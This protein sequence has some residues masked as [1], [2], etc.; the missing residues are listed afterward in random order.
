MAGYRLTVRAG[1]K[2]SRERFGSLD[3]AIEA[4][5]DRAEK[6][7]ADGPL[8]PV[9]A[10]REFEPGDRVAARIE[11]SRGGLLRSRDAGIDVMGDGRMVAYS[12]GM[13][14]ESIEPR[15]GRTHFDEVRRM[16]S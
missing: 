4:L 3:E 10:L 2:V 1:G 16:L 7:R 9:K 8:A 12:G 13:R 11:L 5:Q 14:R 6:V 15:R